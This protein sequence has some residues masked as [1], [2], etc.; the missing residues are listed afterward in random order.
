MVGENHNGTFT[1]IDMKDFISIN[2]FKRGQ[3]C[4]DDFKNTDKETLLNIK[5]IS[6]IGEIE[7]F[8]DKNYFTLT[9]SNGNRY[10]IRPE[11][12]EKLIYQLK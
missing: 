7:D 1:N 5:H 12:K 4:M 10:F 2:Y 9:M 11:Y 3:I 6:E 8:N